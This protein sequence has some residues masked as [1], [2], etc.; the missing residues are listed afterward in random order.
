MG[1]EGA[2]EARGVKAGD[3][4]VLLARGGPE[5]GEP[6]E[7]DDQCEDEGRRQEPSFEADAPAARG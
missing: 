7:D 2:G 6:G 4:G 5:P 1:F 3:G